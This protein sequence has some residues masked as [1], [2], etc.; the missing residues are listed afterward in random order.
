MNWRQLAKLLADLGPCRG[1]SERL[2]SLGIRKPRHSL[3]D[4]SRTRKSLK[5]YR[6]QRLLD[7]GR[8][9]STSGSSGP[10]RP[11]RSNKMVAETCQILAGTI[12]RN[13]NRILI[14]EKPSRHIFL[15][16]DAPNRDA[17]GLVRVRP[18]AFKVL[19]TQTSR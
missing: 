4:C 9:I 15:G 16:R 12:S 17:R 1:R 6:H 10:T 2:N 5:Q 3:G 19:I 18:P 13:L 11:P 14:S 7:R 8:L